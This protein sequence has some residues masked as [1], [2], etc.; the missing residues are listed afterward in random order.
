[1]AIE[2]ARMGPIATQGH[3]TASRQLLQVALDR[4]NQSLKAA[5][6][7]RSDSSD[8]QTA[9]SRLEVKIKQ[10]QT[11]LEKAAGPLGR[12]AWLRG[13]TGWMQRSGEARDR[14][15]ASLQAL[16]SE[17]SNLMRELL[18]ENEA[19]AQLAPTIQRELTELRNRAQVQIALIESLQ[20]R[21]LDPS[22]PDSIRELVFREI[23]P[24]ESKNLE[25]LTTQVQLLDI[26]QTAIAQRMKANRLILESGANQEA[27]IAIHARGVQDQSVSTQ[28][29]QASV[30]LTPAE[31][32]QASRRFQ[33]ALSESGE[34]CV[35]P[36]L[37]EGSNVLL[38]NRSGRI[39]SRQ[40]SGFYAS[41]GR[42]V[43]SGGGDFGI[44]QVYATHPNLRFRGIQVGM[45]VHRADRSTTVLGVSADG[46]LLMA[47]PGLFG[48]P[49]SRADVGLIE[50][51][52]FG[53]ERR[54][55]GEFVLARYG[56]ILGE[57]VNYIG[58][59]HRVLGYRAIDSS[60][61]LESAVNSE[62]RVIVPVKQLSRSG[63]QE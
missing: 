26:N 42:A 46:G 40:V 21:S 52:F 63:S 50:E 27:L 29:E 36:F 35:H 10:V 49:G 14:Q 57:V 53:P 19:L 54:H 34:S 20:R 28:P 38:V 44:N 41:L 23:F 3:L 30:P 55:L 15:M 58:M 7:T 24:T 11:E 39:F 1:M 43:V 47:R 5:L 32:D 31:R 8:A 17:R 18:E 62:K 45:P 51:Q 13:L 59:P 2:S 37:C 9:A 22:L 48:R 56:V 4:S 61:L 6:L 33:S 12:S 25:A 60:L 16:L